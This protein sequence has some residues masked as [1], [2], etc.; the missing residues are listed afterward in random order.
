MAPVLSQGIAPLFR[1]SLRCLQEV[2]GRDLCSEGPA[3]KG[4][5]ACVEAQVWMRQECPGRALSRAVPPQVLRAGPMTCHPG[6]IREGLLA[7]S[8]QCDRLT[9]HLRRESGARVALSSWEPA[10]PDL[11]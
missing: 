4:P 9:A 8:A 7:L 3:D 5:E 6:K 10:A 11:V 2:P 1:G